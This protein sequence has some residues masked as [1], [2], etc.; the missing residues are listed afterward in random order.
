MRMFYAMTGALAR[1][2]SYYDVIGLSAPA[3]W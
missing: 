2:S 3:R 1:D